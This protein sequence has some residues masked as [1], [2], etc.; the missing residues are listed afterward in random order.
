[1]LHQI[2]VQ[3]ALPVICRNYSS[4]ALPVAD[5]L[6]EIQIKLLRVFLLAIHSHLYSFVLRFLLLQMHATSTVSTVQL[7]YTVKEKNLTENRTPFPVV[8]EIHT[9]TSCL[10]TLKIMPR[11]STK[12]YVH[13]FGFW[14]LFMLYFPQSVEAALYLLSDRG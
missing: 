14:N 1:M 8:Y 6:D 7:L 5:F 10:R 4:C 12:L 9:E 3:V 13:E 2:L 11:T